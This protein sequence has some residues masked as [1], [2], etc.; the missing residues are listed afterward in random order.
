MW[1]HAPASAIPRALERGTAKICLIMSSNNIDDGD[2]DNEDE[3][4]INWNTA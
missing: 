3:I 2:G 4:S 1:I